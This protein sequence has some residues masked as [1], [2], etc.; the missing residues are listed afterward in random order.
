[1]TPVDIPDAEAFEAK[2]AALIPDRS[3]FKA[4][5]CCLQAAADRISLC[6]KRI[7]TIEV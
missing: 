7:F 4:T 5:E 6:D 3:K 2:N 1:L